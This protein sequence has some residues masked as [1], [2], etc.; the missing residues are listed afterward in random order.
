MYQAKDLSLRKVIYQERI[1][2]TVNKIVSGVL[3]IDSYLVVH[4][5]TIR[6]VLKPKPPQEHS[7]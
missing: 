4:R 3:D 5:I 2:A 7:T 6:L 1:V